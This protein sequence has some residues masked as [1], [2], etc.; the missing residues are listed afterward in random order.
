MTFWNKKYI[1]NYVVF[2]IIFTACLVLFV[3]CVG[4]V[5]ELTK[6][7]NPKF[8]RLIILIGVPVSLL[9]VFGVFMDYL[10]KK[11]PSKDKDLSDFF[12]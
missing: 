8:L 11:M 5:N 1:N 4:A 6:N 12:R 7:I 9:Y 2:C 10:N 3:L